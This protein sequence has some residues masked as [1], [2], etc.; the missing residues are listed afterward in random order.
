MRVFVLSAGV[1][2]SYGGPITEELLPDAMVKV[3]TKRGYVRLVKR[4]DE[5]LAYAFPNYNPSQC[6][7]PNIERGEYC[8]TNHIKGEDF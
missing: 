3:R 7:Y 4:I 1:S 2:K 8:L 6:I 5:V